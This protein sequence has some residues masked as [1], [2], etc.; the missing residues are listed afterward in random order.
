MNQGGQGIHYADV[1]LTAEVGH[2]P[3]VCRLTLR[4]RAVGALRVDQ[5]NQK[6]GSAGARD[7]A[8][9]EYLIEGRLH[10]TPCMLEVYRRG[11]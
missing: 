10:H 1:M 11:G 7:V 5:K 6:I 3:V 4:E 2:D 8:C 9:T